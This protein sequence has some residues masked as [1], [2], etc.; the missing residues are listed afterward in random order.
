MFKGAAAKLLSHVFGQ[1]IDK[2]DSSQLEMEV[3]NGKVSL[4]GVSLLNDVFIKNQIPFILKKGN[5][6]KI[7][8]SL[9]WS[10]LNT[11]SCN[12][13]INQVFALTSLSN[14]SSFTDKISDIFDIEKGSE[15]NMIDSIIIKVVDNL[16]FEINQVHIRV[17]NERDGILTAFGITIGKIESYTIDD[18]GEMVFQADSDKDLQK[19]LRIS[20]FGVYIDT[21]VKPIDISNFDTEMFQSMNSN[22][23]QF[24]ISPMT[25]ESKIVINR[26]ES[27]I[28]AVNVFFNI[29][30]VDIV[31]DSNQWKFIA[32]LGYFYQMFAKRS[33]FS[34]F[35]RPSSYGEK[36]EGQWWRYVGECATFR[37]YSEKLNT[38]KVLKYLKIRNIYSKSYKKVGLK[39]SQS[40]NELKKLESSLSKRDIELI[41]AIH[42]LKDKTVDPMIISHDPPTAFLQSIKMNY[43]VNCF[44]LSL[45]SH[46]RQCISKFII[47]NC[48][49]DFR[50]DGFDFYNSLL[51]QDI[52]V[53]NGVHKGIPSILSIQK[54]I[55]SSSLMIDI[56]SKINQPKSYNITFPALLGYV[57][58][59]WIYQMAKFFTTNFPIIKRNEENSE[60]PLTRIEIQTIIESHLSADVSIKIPRIKLSF[61]YLVLPDKPSLD[62][63]MDR[64][65]FCNK[66]ENGFAVMNSDSLFEKYIWEYDKLQFFLE[67]SPI[68][69]QLS[70]YAD[71]LFNIMPYS[72]SPSFVL[73][74]FFDNLVLKV[75]TFQFL[76]IQ[77]IV[78]YIIDS[79][80]FD[81]S[82][83]KGFEKAIL[84]N[85]Q[86]PDAKIEFNHK[87]VELLKVN[88][89]SISISIKMFELLTNLKISCK[90]MTMEDYFVKS[91]GNH[92]MVI[93]SSA[94][95]DSIII[96]VN[97]STSNNDVKIQTGV[98]NGVFVSLSLNFLINFF[99][100]PSKFQKA[101]PFLDPYPERD[102]IF[103]SKRSKLTKVNLSIPEIESSLYFGNLYVGSFGSGD[104]LLSISIVNDQFLLSTEIRNIKVF[105]SRN[106]L[107]INQLSLKLDNRTITIDSPM[108]QGITEKLFLSNFA[109]FVRDLIK[110]IPINGILIPPFLYMINIGL[111]EVSFSTPYFVDVVLIKISGFDF[112]SDSIESHKL[113][114]GDFSIHS[115]G[116]QLF[117]ASSISSSFVFLLCSS[118]FI[119]DIN[120]LENNNCGI[121]KTKELIHQGDL[122]VFDNMDL[123]VLKLSG[124]MNISNIV[125]SLRKLDLFKI[126][127]LINVNS[128]GNTGYCP[129]LAFDYNIGNVE[130]HLPQNIIDHSVI[131]TS[132]SVKQSQKISINAG[133]IYIKN[134]DTNKEVITII[135]KFDSPLLVYSKKSICIGIDEIVF[136]EFAKS[137]SDFMYTFQGFQNGSFNSNNR[138][139]FEINISSLKYLMKSDYSN[140]LIQIISQFNASHFDTKLKLLFMN[141]SVSYVNCSSMNEYPPF[142]SLD[143]ISF[144][145]TQEGEGIDSSFSFG[146]T[147]MYLTVFEWKY[148]I[149]KVIQ[150]ISSWKSIMGRFKLGLPNSPSNQQI[151]C[152]LQP[153]SLYLSRICPNTMKMVPFTEL[154]IHPTT[155]SM[156]IISNSIDTNISLCISV[157]ARNPYVEEWYPVLDSFSLKYSMYLSDSKSVFSFDSMGM[158]DI[159]LTS[160]FLG[161]L[162][163]Y[164]HSI[165]SI[166]FP[167][168]RIE[169]FLAH[170]KNQT[171]FELSIGY[172]QTCNIVKNNEKIVLEG[173]NQDTV[174]SICNS[175]DQTNGFAFCIGKTIFPALIIPQMVVNMELED[176]DRIITISSPFRFISKVSIPVDFFLIDPNDMPYYFNV[177]NKDGSLF[178]ESLPNQIILVEKGYQIGNKQQRLILKNPK[179][180]IL[181][182]IINTTRGPLYCIIQQSINIETKIYE[183]N[184]SPQHRI[185]NEMPSIININYS[186]SSEIISVP[187]SEG[188][189]IFGMPNQYG[190]LTLSIKF[191]QYSSVNRISFSSL[192]RITSPM[193]ICLYA[194]DKKSLIYIAI[195][196]ER[197]LSDSVS[198]YTVY[199]PVVMFNNLSL[200]LA[201]SHRKDL[202][203][204]PFKT[205]MNRMVYFFGTPKFYSDKECSALISIPRMTHPSET[206]IDC[207]TP[208]ISSV[209]FMQHIH[210]P[211]VY[212]PVQYD[213][214]R[215][216]NPY[217]H[218]LSVTLDYYLVIHN[219]LENRLVLIPSGTQNEISIEPN[220]SNP[221][222][223]CTKELSFDVKMFGYD[224]CINILLSSPVKTAFRLIGD[225]NNY[226]IELEVLEEGNGIGAHF[227]QPDFPTSVVITNNLPEF[228]FYCY[229]ISEKNAFFFPSLTTSI[230]AFD[231]PFQK[232]LINL[233]FF[234]RTFSVSLAKDME[235]MNLEGTEIYIDIK[236]IGSG[237]RVLTL[238]MQQELPKMDSTSIS[239][240]LPRI[241]VSMIDYCMREIVNFVVQNIALTSHSSDLDNLI[242]FSIDSIQGD[243]QIAFTPFPVFCIGQSNQ[244]HKF[245]VAS[246]VVK[247][248]SSFMLSYKYI[249]VCIQQIDLFLDV[250]FLSDIYSIFAGLSRKNKIL[251]NRF[252]IPSQKSTK[253]TLGRVFSIQELEIHPILINLTL[254]AKTGR[255][256][257]LPCSPHFPLSKT[258]FLP[259]IT[260]SP[261]QFKSIS[262]I[263]CNASWQ[264]L[265]RTIGDQ[266]INSFYSQIWRIIGHNGLLL[267]AFGIAESFGGG[268][269]STFYDPFTANTKS[270]NQALL[271]VVHGSKELVQNTVTSAL[272]GG[273]GL[274]RNL[275]SFVGMLTLDD[276]ISV[277]SSSVNQSATNTILNG[278][279]SLGT[280][281]FDGVTGIVT[282][283]IS[284]AKKDGFTG[285][286][287]GLG[288]GVLGVVTKPVSGVLDCGAG[289]IGGVRKA[290]SDN[291][292]LK[293]Y[294]S[295]QAFILKKI[296]K[297][298]KFGSAIQSK[299]HNFSKNM[300]FQ[301]EKLLFYTITPSKSSIFCI[302]DQYIV[303]LSNP[304]LD[305]IIKFKSKHIE[306]A[307]VDGENVYIQSPKLGT[308]K[309]KKELVLTC[310]NLEI[311]NQVYQM[312][313]TN[314]FLTNL[315][316]YNR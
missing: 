262:M 260:S 12:V 151:F 47:E 14:D 6:G 113:A 132:L 117:Q 74:A 72:Q 29:P 180:G 267:N 51:I 221:A 71:L 50:K 154:S 306:N 140:T 107:C 303:I 284:G 251:N 225:D 171:V 208:G 162:D 288:K 22:N 298:D 222:Y 3:W 59:S 133:R 294:R 227:R 93:N 226:I 220:S 263:D 35:N 88:L 204:L 177:I 89:N 5:I 105:D 179:R 127:D 141:I 302:T 60:F 91:H 282:K 41:K 16:I 126:F 203:F 160:F 252:L 257:L 64:I 274:I 98:I 39:K 185:I 85:F 297:F 46:S 94:D 273:E 232:H 235:P 48:T 316:K 81:F 178:L 198:I 242:E 175:V 210:D 66:K 20:D 217:D 181:E 95:R 128:E 38:S 73:N 209:V 49:G 202:P 145:S 32:D 240:F 152:V 83:K 215:L 108:I 255:H 82:T 295:S 312:I 135:P 4:E 161:D 164:I 258:L 212:L 264:Y 168:G 236:T 230:F 102:I 197:D 149:P 190:K 101:Y 216:M 309:Q 182:Y 45:L 28:G 186:S 52:S 253:D 195:Q 272:Q 270:A 238:S 24:L 276:G 53:Y 290:I 311:A 234:T 310:E 268:L 300:K 218:S 291:D 174:F 173:I 265:K 37:K 84:L 305:L 200:P 280:G 112:R 241:H 158:V 278:F 183:V 191:E 121:E 277:S 129:D 97:S 31:F 76:L 299:I 156:D 87:A 286:L 111:I 15:G 33:Q 223:F 199:S 124:Y 211:S 86:I 170:I 11:E 44:C 169:K 176:G 36:M 201:V 163:S 313:I 304:S 79:T 189:D 67:N 213:V 249:S 18:K 245:I 166:S 194:E 27:K 269:K 150:E 80:T 17:E 114:F 136:Y 307:C 116:N 239:V 120:V 106:Q 13:N 315:N 144:N 58:F 196:L 25:L 57:D 40:D 243:D 34:K 228:S 159:H 68:S 110:F 148:M 259:N 292:V 10:K 184:I 285:V 192:V 8:L 206:P 125:S 237:T 77:S 188:I 146:P 207:S 266:Y 92:L 281:I 261:L 205:F 63:I 143:A 23:H 287:T 104:I 157:L 142:L 103:K 246:A 165:D 314:V 118:D 279:V 69:N 289:V 1:F 219:H 214:S 9:P 138:M 153:F 130:V 147:S 65:S 54:E 229:Q 78:F 308:S 90:N 233:T 55:D 193:I 172:N 250:A 231:A 75:S 43:K 122:K 61:P 134:Q 296:T 62:I 100:Y 96:D 248:D 247:R 2:I 119:V 30:L 99:R 301:T 56:I 224:T 256:T 254:H 123:Y 109:L 19:V 131:I 26:A 7:M 293:R 155:F 271:L 115:S 139:L 275:S 21:N 70:G 244:N 167:E 42:S 283:P 187:S 137:M